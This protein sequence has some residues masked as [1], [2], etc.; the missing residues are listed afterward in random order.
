MKLLPPDSLCLFAA[1]A[2]A[3]YTGKTTATAAVAVSVAAA[4]AA[5]PIQRE[6]VQVRFPSPPP[7]Y[8]PHTGH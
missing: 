3:L 4:A 8:T 7:V 2:W 6:P 1:L 5:L